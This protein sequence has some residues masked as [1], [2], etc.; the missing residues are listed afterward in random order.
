M[1]SV[2]KKAKPVLESLTSLSR[3]CAKPQPTTAD[4]LAACEMIRGTLE[5]TEVYVVRGSDPHCLKLGDASDP[6]TYEIKQKGYW[7]IWNGLAEAGRPNEAAMLKVDGRIV[8]SGRVL[9]PASDC[10]HVAA[11][12]I[13]SESNSD[14]VVARGP[15]PNG[16]SGEQVSYFEV[17]R[18]M[19]AQLVVNVLDTDRTKR[20]RAQFEAVAGVARAFS[21]ATRDEEVLGSLATA[22]GKASGMEWVTITLEDPSGHITERASNTARHEGTEAYRSIVEARG[23]WGDEGEGTLRYRAMMQGGR[24]WIIPDVFDP[25]LGFSPELLAYY[26]RAHILCS[27]AYP[28]QFHGEVFGRVAFT[29]TTA[30]AFDQ[31]ELVLL[32]A[33]SAQA[34]TTIQGLR[35]YRD[36]DRSREEL[37]EYASKLEEAHRAEHFL[38]RT[39]PLTSLPNRRLIEEVMEAEC[40]RAGRYGQPMSVMMSDLDRFKDVNDRYGHL[41]GDEVLKVVADLA[42]RSCRAADLVGRWGGDEFVFVL[43][44]TPAE[45]ARVLGQRFSEVLAG[46]ELSAAGIAAGT[47]VSVSSGIAEVG[48]DTFGDSRLLLEKA[49]RALYIAKEAGRGRIEL[50]RQQAEAA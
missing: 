46:A 17:A 48:P 25:S 35:L 12:L 23:I 11:I 44:A 7:F 34:S 4:V 45:E 49:D 27:A 14:M 37:R 29:A 3:V 10:S 26:E 15:W 19:L 32:S 28:L 6:T 40:A 22:L 39:D 41:V 42:R 13:G 9:R 31:S 43:P 24:P 50:Y 16:L 38:A 36:L 20:Q 18:T 33:L 47:P 30:R 2:P 5:A 1:G 8:L 21:E